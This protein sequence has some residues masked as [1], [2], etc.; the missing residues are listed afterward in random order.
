MRS[1]F[2]AVTLAAF[3]TLA[4]AAAP[5]FAQGLLPLKP[6]PPAPIKPYQAVAVTAPPVDNDPSF[7]AFRKQFGDAVAKEVNL[8]QSSNSFATGSSQPAAAHPIPRPVGRPHNERRLV[9]SCR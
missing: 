5:A 9:S 8:H 3:A 6:P 7:V 1:F 4:L 2:P